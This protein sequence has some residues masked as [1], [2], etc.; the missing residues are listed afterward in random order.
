MPCYTFH[1]LD[2]FRVII[3]K[4]D[5]TALLEAKHAS[6]HSVL[7]MHP[8]VLKQKKGVVARCIVK[9]AASCEVVDLDAN[10]PKT[11]AMLQIAPE[12]VFEVFIA[13]RADVFR[14]QLRA[15]YLNSEVRQFFDPYC[16]LPTVSEQDVY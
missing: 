3:S 2:F 16:F 12:G 1:G 6:P 15:A 9:G 10:P 11:H 8:L 13:E 14:Y 5:L 4:T 7:G